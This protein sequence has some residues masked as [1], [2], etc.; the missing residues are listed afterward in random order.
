MLGG[1]GVSML[2][3][4][5]GNRPQD[6][7]AFRNSKRVKVKVLQK[8]SKRNKRGFISLFKTVTGA[9]I[10]RRTGTWWG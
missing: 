1:L 10:N 7:G 2:N 3:I 8:R 9:F 6:F 4:P 5:S